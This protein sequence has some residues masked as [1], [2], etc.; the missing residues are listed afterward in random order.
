MG[1]H[2]KRSPIPVAASRNPHSNM[3]SMKLQASRPWS[4]MNADRFLPSSQRTTEI[5]KSSPVKPLS[6]TNTWHSTA[7]RMSDSDTEGSCNRP[8]GRTC[9]NGTGW[10]GVCGICLLPYWE[11]TDRYFNP[12]QKT[13]LALPRR[14]PSLS[15]PH[16]STDLGIGQRRVH[17]RFGRFP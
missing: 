7:I 3:L 2:T 17:Q 15:W 8:F 12:R 5:K 4:S 9:R 11:S 16:R 14:Q 1:T 10:A 6:A 13:S